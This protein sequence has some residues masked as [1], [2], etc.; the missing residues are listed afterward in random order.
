MDTKVLTDKS[1]KN[2]KDYQIKSLISNLI[3]YRSMTNMIIISCY[4]KINQTRII[5]AMFDISYTYSAT[6]IKL[7]QAMSK[8]K[9]GKT[10]TTKVN[11]IMK[12]ACTK[13]DNIVNKFKLRDICGRLNINQIPNLIDYSVITI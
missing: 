13:I 3:E 9:L 10:K 2:V 4:G 7:E 1:G 11:D 12:G 8:Y 5:D 6:I